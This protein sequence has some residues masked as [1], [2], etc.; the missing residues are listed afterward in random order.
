MSKDK[1]VSLKF[2][3]DKTNNIAEVKIDSGF[4]DYIDKIIEAALTSL[5]DSIKTNSISNQPEFD[6]IYSYLKQ[7]LKVLLI[8]EIR[9]HNE[10]LIHLDKDKKIEY[11]YNIICYYLFIINTVI[12]LITGNQDKLK[13]L[14]L[15]NKQKYPPNIFLKAENYYLKQNVTYINALWE[16]FNSTPNI[17]AVLRDKNSLEFFRANNRFTKYRSLNKNKAQKNK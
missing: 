15:F 2:D 16:V 9:S 3:S 17:S 7:D 10:Y 4:P 12:A 1:F 5:I 14:K 13:S 8:N 11:V 6:D